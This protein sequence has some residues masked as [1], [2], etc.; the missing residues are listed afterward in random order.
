MC[1]CTCVYVCA[2]I[3]SAHVEIRRQL[4]KVC[5]LFPPCEFQRYG[6]QV[7]S[8]GDKHLYLLSH[9]TALLPQ[10]L[11]HHLAFLPVLTRCS[12]Q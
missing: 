6:T 3:H 2:C 9:L 11:A 10:V 1:V 4:V 12:Y 7:F 8:L 5:F